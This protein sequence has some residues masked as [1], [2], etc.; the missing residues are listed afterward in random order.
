[1]IDP[2]TAEPYYNWERHDTALRVVFEG[3]RQAGFDM[4]HLRQQGKLALVID[5]HRAWCD[6]R[7]I[8]LIDHMLT[9]A[10]GQAQL[11]NDW[12]RF[13][14]IFASSYRWCFEQARVQE[15]ED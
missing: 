11:T 12:K 1:M 9:I 3:M 8:L 5:C 14:A 2:V 10:G 6:C 7:V 15:E 13:E 4:T